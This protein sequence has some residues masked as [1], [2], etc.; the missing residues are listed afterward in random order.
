MND[1]THVLVV[2]DHEDIRGPLADFLRRYGL[3][4]TTAADGTALRNLLTQET[5]DLIILDIMMP[6][7][8][9]LSLCRYIY[10][11]TGIP[12]MLLTAVA[13]PADRIAGLELGAD[14]YIVKPFDPRELLARIR[15]I[16]RRIQR[17][18]LP[19]KTSEP[20]AYRFNDW[21]LDLSSHQLKSDQG[22]LIDL[23]PVEFRLLKAFAE[24]PNRVLSRDK[25]L[26]LINRDAT[27]IFDR[28]VDSHISRLRKKL[29]DHTRNLLQTAW[30]DGYLFAASV[31]IRS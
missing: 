7:E 14:D 26:D 11:H 15:V 30:G 10:E 9:G 16:L 5:F 20:A 8:D 3:K 12:V 21:L 6:G 1:Q 31:E 28:A 23:S 4:V 17:Q 13:D 25:L 2:D 18:I 24:H 27:Q 22:F 29:G 19:A